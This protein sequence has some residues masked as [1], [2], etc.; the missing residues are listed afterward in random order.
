ME[1]E[2]LFKAFIK[3]LTIH[4][5]PCYS[6]SACIA[7]LPKNELKEIAFNLRYRQTSLESVPHEFIEKR[8]NNVI[9]AIYDFAPQEIIFSTF[10][11][12]SKYCKIEFPFSKSAREKINAFNDNDDYISDI[13]FLASRCIIFMFENN[14]NITYVVP[15]ETKEYLLKLVSSDPDLK[16]AGKKEEFHEY[17][18]VLTCLYGVCPAQV[19]IS[20]WNRDNPENQFANKEDFKKQIESCYLVTTHFDLT[21]STISYPELENDLIKRIKEN[22]ESFDVYMPTKEEIH[23]HF[24]CYDYDD[25]TEEFKKMQNLIFSVTKNKALAENVTYT[26]VAFLKTGTD[27]TRFEDYLKE[28]YKISF[29]KK[30]SLQFNKLIIAMGMT[31]HLWSKWGNTGLTGMMN[32]LASLQNGK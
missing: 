22:R 28:R 20:L 8:I 1:N 14:G 31:F 9:N 18:A 17:A 24:R 2:E 4:K 3:D 11:A 7:S 27:I 16:N 26:I 10:K 21:G 19:F 13:G 30:H 32:F 29:D 25:K 6:L 23:E 15:N 12:I 5:E